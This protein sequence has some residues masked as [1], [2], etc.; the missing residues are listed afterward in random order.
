MRGD[1]EGSVNA[2]SPAKKPKAP[3]RVFKGLVRR[4]AEK[5]A[6]DMTPTRQSAKDTEDL[7]TIAA[8]KSHVVELILR[9]NPEYEMIK[10]IL[11]R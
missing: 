6:A 7:S 4:T 11:D 2:E 8:E 1:P 9:S 10:D 5:E 3:R